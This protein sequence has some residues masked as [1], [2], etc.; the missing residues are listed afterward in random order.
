MEQYHKEEDIDAMFHGIYRYN[1][2][3]KIEIICIQKVD[4]DVSIAPGSGS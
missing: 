1:I 3:T 2:R 4:N